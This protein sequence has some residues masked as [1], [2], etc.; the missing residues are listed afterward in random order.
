[1]SNMYILVDMDDGEVL[2]YNDEQTPAENLT[3]DL[4][5]FTMP[6]EGLTISAS[7]LVGKCY[8]YELLKPIK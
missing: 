1:M 4:E 6:L 8:I 7:D 3:G 2:S 5:E